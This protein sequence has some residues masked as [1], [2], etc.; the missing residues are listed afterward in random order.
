MA[1]SHIS[2]VRWNRAAEYYRTVKPALLRFRKAPERVRVIHRR[3]Y[4]MPDAP[5]I[6]L[7]WLQGC[8]QRGQPVRTPACCADVL[9]TA[10][11][12]RI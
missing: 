2:Q 10:E 7:D 6:A 5:G 9:A 8:Y 1:S 3:N 4:G 12:S 11:L